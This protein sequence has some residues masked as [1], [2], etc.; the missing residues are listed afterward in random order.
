MF[1]PGVRATD[2]CAVWRAARIQGRSHIQFKVK[3]K[4]GLGA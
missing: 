3:L 1:T 4:V 2:V